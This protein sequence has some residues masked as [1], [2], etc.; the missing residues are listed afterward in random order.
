MAAYYPN[1]ASSTQ[2]QH[3]THLLHSLTTLYPCEHCASHLST[4]Y[5]TN[6]PDQHVSGRSQLSAYLCRVH[7]DVRD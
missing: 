6:P 3:A 2:Q 1:T 7:N 4:Y 5:H